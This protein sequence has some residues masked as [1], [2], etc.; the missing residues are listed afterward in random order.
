MR[1]ARA[2]LLCCTLLLLPAVLPYRVLA[3]DAGTIVGTVTRADKTPVH[4]VRV[5]LLATSM[6]A[7]TSSDGTFRIAGIPA[8]TY[9]IELRAIGFAVK[10]QPVTVEGNATARLPFELVASATTI[11]TVSIRA[12]AIPPHLVGFEERRGRG[13]GRYF[14][15]AQIDKM[16][17]RQITDILRRVPGFQFQPARSDGYSVQT[18]RTGT[19]VCPVMYYIN[20]SPF[21][22]GPDQTINSFLDPDAVD[23]I[24]V[25]SGSSSIPPQFNSSMHN[26]RCGVIVIWTRVGIDKS[27]K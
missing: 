9:N 19:R 10:I 15:R 13:S 14:T 8:G 7:E 6:E 23:G 21:P 5:R 3:Q 22:V 2:T 27:V 1:E 25:Y 16:Q 4:H 11:D 17:P 12:P 18:G 20:G 26:S 24:E